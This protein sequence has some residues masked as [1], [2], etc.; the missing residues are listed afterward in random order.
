MLPSFLLPKTLNAA[1]T[2]A[3][4]VTGISATLVT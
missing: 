3:A 4:G 2:I 1:H